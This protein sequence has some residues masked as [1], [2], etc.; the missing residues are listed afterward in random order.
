MAVASSRTCSTAQVLIAYRAELLA[1]GFHPEFVCDL[2]KDAAQTLLK[3]EGLHVT[4]TTPDTPQGETTPT[5]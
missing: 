3:D 2:V 1:G 4:R 5:L